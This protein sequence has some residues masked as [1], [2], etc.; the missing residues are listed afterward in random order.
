MADFRD[1]TPSFT[2]VS[3]CR[4]LVSE[5]LASSIFRI[6]VDI[7]MVVMMAES[8]D[9][10]CCCLWSLSRRLVYI[11]VRRYAPRSKLV[12]FSAYLFRNLRLYVNRCIILRMRE[13]FI[14][15]TLSLVLRPFLRGEEK[16]QS[17]RKSG[18]TGYLIS[19]RFLIVVFRCV[20][21]R[22]VTYGV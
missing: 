17:V 13:Q 12:Y 20:Q 21:Q 6:R 15:G 2:N 19:F 22:A 1:Y 9:C 3:F 10:G 8:D 7:L 16:R 4:A 5:P 14:Q 18:D 11:H